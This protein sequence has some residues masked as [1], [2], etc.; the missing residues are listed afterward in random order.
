MK[1]VKQFDEFINE[2]FLVK[3]SLEVAKTIINIISTKIS[4]LFFDNI[5]EPLEYTK[6]LLNIFYVA[7]SNLT[8][9]QKYLYENEY[10]MKDNEVKDLKFRISQ[11]KKEFPNGINIEQIKNNM[12]KEVQ[13]HKR[14]KK[15]DKETII[16][17]IVDYDDPIEKIKK[18]AITEAIL[19][20]PSSLIFSN[21][22]N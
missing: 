10:N 12:I 9:Y 5:D 6:S 18:K 13:N 7:K 15:E 1:N 22:I 2:G 11:I 20:L 4:K 3:N 19:V 14:F 8:E 21:I 16:D 17:F